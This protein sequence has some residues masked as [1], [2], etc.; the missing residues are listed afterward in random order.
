[1]TLLTKG[2]GPEAGKLCTPKLL[3]ALRAGK[4]SPPSQ[5]TL[6]SAARLQTGSETDAQKPGPPLKKAA[7]THP[8]PGETQLYRELFDAVD[9]KA[10]ALR[11]I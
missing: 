5:C 11:G 7:L 6:A 9:R 1:M 3:G 4:T 8:Y 10:D 2:P